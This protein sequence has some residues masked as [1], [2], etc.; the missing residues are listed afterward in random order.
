MTSP[1]RRGRKANSKAPRSE[2]SSKPNSER[3]DV[4]DGLDRLADDGPKHLVAQATDSA[5]VGPH[6]SYK[7]KS[8]S[9]GP[10][11]SSHS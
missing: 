9:T 2:S 4:T 3:Y 7:A 10:G 6:A 5:V 11:V 1:Q 8:S